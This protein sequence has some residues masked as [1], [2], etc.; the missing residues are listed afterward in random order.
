MFKGF[1][2]SCRSIGRF[3]LTAIAGVLTLSVNAQPLPGYAA[4]NGAN[5]SQ[6]LID[7]SATGG[8]AYVFDYA[9]DGTKTGLDML[10]D[11]DAA[12]D[13]EVFTTQFSF[14]LGI[15][16]FAFAGNSLDIGF[17]FVTGQF[18]SY[19]VD[20]GF[21]DLDFMGD[22]TLDE[23]AAAGIYTSAGVGAS[24]RLLADGSVDG[25]IVNV[26]ASNSSGN[27]ATNNPPAAVPEPASLI[28][29]SMAGLMVG[30]RRRKTC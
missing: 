17:D 30:V 13:L 1:K 12:G 29:L 28:L 8:E 7:F 11:L 6:L 22:F 25:W 26:S 2:W 14:G 10:L 20:G 3:S 27:P 23:A 18:W 21:Q 19:W 9:Y 5:T 24:G 4:G 16:G 15:D